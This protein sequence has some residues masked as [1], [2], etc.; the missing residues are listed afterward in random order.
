V[1]FKLLNI[2]FCI[3]IDMTF[4]QTPQIVKFVRPSG[5]KCDGKQYWEI[6]T[7]NDNEGKLIKVTDTPTETTV[8]ALLKIK[9]LSKKRIATR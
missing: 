2:L 4:A 8:A 6:K 5:V 9:R 1:P 7:L 3:S